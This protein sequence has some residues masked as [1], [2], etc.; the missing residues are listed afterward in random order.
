[1]SQPDGKLAMRGQPSEQE[2]RE[3][4]ETIPQQIAELKAK[5][6]D[7]KEEFVIHFKSGAPVVLAVEA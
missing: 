3:A 4:L 2:R 1:M 7:G 6:V 5:Y